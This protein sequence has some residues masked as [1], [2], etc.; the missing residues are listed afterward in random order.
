MAVM[1]I[2]KCACC[3]IPLPLYCSRNNLSSKLSTSFIQDL[4]FYEAIN[5]VFKC[6]KSVISRLGSALRDL[7]LCRYC[8]LNIIRLVKYYNRIAKIATETGSVLSKLLS[9]QSSKL[10]PADKRHLDEPDREANTKDSSDSQFVDDESNS[11]EVPPGLTYLGLVRKK[12][13]RIVEIFDDEDHFDDDDRANDD[14]R[15]ELLVPELSLTG[16]FN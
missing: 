2:P 16:K 10:A 7:E 4:S 12:R 11:E 5:L 6:R 9:V 8:S 3:T 1:S 14:L 13:K 15:V